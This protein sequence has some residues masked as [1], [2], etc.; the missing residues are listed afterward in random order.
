MTY[1][2][3]DPRTYRDLADKFFA[4]AMKGKGDQRFNYEQ[5]LAWDAYAERL[6]ARLKSGK[7]Y[8]EVRREQG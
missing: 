6:A 3:H 8:H 5:A 4:A 1:G 7:F 2:P